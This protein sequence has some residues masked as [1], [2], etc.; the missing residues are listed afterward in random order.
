[1]LYHEALYNI[2]QYYYDLG[3]LIFQKNTISIK[4]YETISLNYPYCQAEYFKIDFTNYSIVLHKGYSNQITMK[5]HASCL[6]KAIYI[7][8]SLDASGLCIIQIFP[9]KP[10]KPAFALKA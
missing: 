5:F 6:F 1:M 4:Y 3:S 2:Y 7:F 10:R 8:K 9:I